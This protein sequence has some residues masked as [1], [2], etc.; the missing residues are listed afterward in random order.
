MKQYLITKDED[1]NNYIE[2]IEQ[3]SNIE[4]PTQT[5]LILSEYQL[6]MLMT[7]LKRKLGWHS[8]Y[9]EGDTVMCT[10]DSGTGQENEG[11]I[12]TAI[13]AGLHTGQ[14]YVVS[15][16]S[17]CSSGDTEAVNLV[18]ITHGWGVKRFKR[19]T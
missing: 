6:W 10:D 15:N 12:S 9:R 8:R 13:S 7:T 18:G 5:G 2:I 14:T 1:F 17:W 16:D 19:I 4:E 3:D 11:E